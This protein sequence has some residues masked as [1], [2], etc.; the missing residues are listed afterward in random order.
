MAEIKGLKDRMLRLRQ[1]IDN[2]QKLAGEADDAGSFLE[3]ELSD[4]HEQFTDHRDD[5]V[6]A[7]GVLGNSSGVSSKQ[8]SD[9]KLPDAV[10]LTAG[11]TAPTE[12]GQ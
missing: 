4:F 7:A 2:I 5:L 1:R 3:M 10:P 6:A 11:S 8:Q 9:E 12:P